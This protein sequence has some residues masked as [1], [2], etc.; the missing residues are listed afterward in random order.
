MTRSGHMRYPGGR[1]SVGCVIGHWMCKVCK[2]ICQHVTISH[3]KAVTQSS[4]TWTLIHAKSLLDSTFRY[5]YCWDA[6]DI[7]TCPATS[8][9]YRHHQ[10]VQD[11]KRSTGH[12]EV[13]GY[14]S[15]Q[16]P[17]SRCHTGV[18]VRCHRYGPGHRASS[19]SDAS[20]LQTIR[21]AL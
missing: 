5:K 14:A 21:T 16:Q 7:Q 9:V 10:H 6:Q 20:Q 17:P 3:L 4:Q 12:G 19:Q 8:H 18:E 2:R 15:T 1:M 13:D 11:V